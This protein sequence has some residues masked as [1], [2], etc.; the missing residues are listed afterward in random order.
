MVSD[1]P[2]FQASGAAEQSAPLDPN[3]HKPISDLLRRLRPIRQ[4]PVWACYALTFALVLVCFGLRYALEGVYDYPFLLFLPGIVLAATLFDRGSG[5]LATGLSA[6]LALYFF[7]EP[8][9]TFAFVPR[10]IGSVVATVLFT[11]IG[12]FL[13]A[14]IEAL[15]N[16]VED[17]GLAYRDLAERDRKLEAGVRELALSEA[18]F[19]SF[20]EAMPTLLFVTDP[21][22]GNTYTNPPFHAYTGLPPK[23]LLGDG[24]L[25][26]IHPDDRDRVAATWAQAVREGSSYEVEYR[27]RRHDG[28]YRWHIGRGRPILDPDGRI[29][30]WLGTCSDIE[31]AKH[32][33]E[34]LRRAEALSRA[35]V[36]HAPLKM[37]VTNPDGSVAHFNAEWRTYTA[38]PG[39]HVGPSWGEVVHPEDLP[40]MRAIRDGAIP[41]GRGYDVE[42]RIREAASGRY[43]WHIG[44]VAPV[45]I[46]EDG[47]IVAWVGGATDIDDI[48]A[49]EARLRASEEQH[50]LIVE[51]ARDYAILTTDLP[52]RI[53]S[54]SPGAEAVFGFDA[55]EIIGQPVDM[56]FTPED[57][58][59]GVPAWERETALRDGHAPDMRWHLRKD[60]DRIWVDGAAWPLHDPEGRETG[61]LKIG[62]DETARRQA[63]LLMQN[64][65]ERQAFLTREVG[66]RVKNNLTIIT[67]LLSLQA[68]NTA[69]AETRAALDDAR[70][71]IN[72]IAQVHDLLWRQG[73]GQGEAI[74]LDAFLHELCE[75]VQRTVPHHRIQFGGNGSVMVPID[76]AVTISLLVNELVTNAVKY[77]Y[78]EEEGGLV[79]VSLRRMGRG[80]LCLEVADNGVGLPSDIA[81]GGVKE[82]SFGTRL[83]RTFTRQLGAEMEIDAGAGGTRVALTMPIN[84]DGPVGA[85]RP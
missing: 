51:R 83:L 56:L 9:H 54:W 75:G 57:R 49:A 43:R 8:R 30:Q 67:S 39:T 78:P 34:A 16:A 46:G 19:R 5:F 66:H 63:E 80:M 79:A 59:A 81:E 62:R 31:E 11:V 37:W 25:R 76:R 35:Y 60:G 13:S 71:R 15:R 48:R 32:A 70:G 27:L 77:A 14:L 29:V 33:Q 72:A 12:L 4:L 84:P 24:W 17:L 42:L 40:G 58:G 1:L 68:R 85:E 18:R 47:D 10:H 28:A 52:G 26:I 45:R 20:T 41:A 69:N 82:G 53:T 7:V 22:G 64:A 6:V 2:P 3:R 21:G 61:F 44:R 50:R 74:D 55:Q 38:Q 73:Q 23:N 36:E 65:V